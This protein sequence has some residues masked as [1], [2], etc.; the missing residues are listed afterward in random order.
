M[1]NKYEK[2]VF[3]VFRIVS[4]FLFLWHGTQKYFNYPPLP[5]G[6]VLPFY[7]VAVAGTVELLGGILIC[8]GLLTRAA[9]FIACGEMAYAYW[10]V[11]AHSALLPLVNKGEPAVLYCFAFLFICAHGAGIWSIDSIL[12][13]RSKSEFKE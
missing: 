8:I 2:Y 5:A 7:I 10:T 3:A 9:S 6:V 13:H 12:K 1:F 4:G 11:H